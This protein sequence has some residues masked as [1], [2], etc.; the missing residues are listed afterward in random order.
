MNPLVS[1]VISMTPCQNFGQNKQGTE[2]P[3][4]KIQDYKGNKGKREKDNDS[5]PHS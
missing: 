1:T 2:L 5:N 4:E 3:A